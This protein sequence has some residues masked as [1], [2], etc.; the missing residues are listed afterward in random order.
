MPPRKTPASTGTD[1]ANFDEELA[2]RARGAKKVVADVGLGKFLG[3]QG[4]SLTYN[5][6]AMPDDEMEAI[7]IDSMYENTYYAD[8][9]NSDKPTPPDC[10]AYGPTDLNDPDADILEAMSPHEKAADPQ[11]PTCK[12]CPNNEWDS[13]PQ[14]TGKACGNK[15]RLSLIPAFEDMDVGDV[16][17]ADLAF[18]KVPVTSV[19]NW[20]GFVKQ[21]DQIYPGKPTFCFVVLIK[22]V[23]NK[24]TQFEVQFSFVREVERSLWKALMDKQDSTRAE[25]LQP[26]P[27]PAPESEKPAA[28]G[29]SAGK[30]A[31]GRAAAAP[32][33]GRR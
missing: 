32:V 18:L 16:A 30:I 12:G 26:Y 1:I 31:G 28:R 2:R 6:N 29:K 4:G 8:A 15:R 20:A 23:P 13:A 9:F 17:K 27:E 7:V 11:H 25:M 5:G 10:Y 3:L 14:G 24:K 33:R 21:L 19:K 22:V